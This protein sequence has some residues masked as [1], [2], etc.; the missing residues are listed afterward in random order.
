MP[1]APA[2]A[3]T[4]PTASSG[5]ARA[6]TTAMASERRALRG[7]YAITPELADTDAARASAS[8][9]ASRAARRSCSTAPRTPA[10]SLAPRAGARAS[11]RSAAP[12]GAALHRERLGRARARECGAD[13]V[14]LGREDGDARAARRA[15]P[16]RHHRRLVLR[17]PAARARR[18]G[19]RGADYVA[20][21]SMFASRT[22][23][24]A[25]ARAARR[26]IAAGARGRRDLPVAAIGGITLGQR[27]AR[28]RRRRRH[29]RG[30]LRSL[31][32]APTYR[33][34]RA[35][36]RSTSSRHRPPDLRCTNAAAPS[37]N[38]PRSS[39]PAA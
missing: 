22:K 25:R 7:L 33:G 34:G 17:R 39:F 3:S 4:C 14:H 19:A 13:G 8:R 26:L 11:R 23:P 31:R 29:D 6:T 21:G 30:D 5:R 10:A 35:R 16:A 2:W 37:L 18:R 28:G 1:S 12:H 38:A 15:L 24:G 27:R 32:R 36:L 9:A 20:I